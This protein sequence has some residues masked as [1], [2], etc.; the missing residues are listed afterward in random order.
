MSSS[1]NSGPIISIQTT[2]SIALGTSN[3]PPSNSSSQPLS[4]FA[5]TP[6]DELLEMSPDKMSPEE[7]AAYVQRCATLRQSAQT[8]KAALQ[9]EPKAKTKKA[10]SV[11]A[12]KSFLDQI[13]G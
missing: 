8:R 13:L 2:Q 11:S 1:P 12:A 7:L 10:D 5:E 3:T 6:I 9:T 4:L